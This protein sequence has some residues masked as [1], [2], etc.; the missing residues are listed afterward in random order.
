M[1]SNKLSLAAD[2]TDIKEQLAALTTAVTILTRFAE[3]G[4][5]A[6]FTIA[7]FRVRNRLSE[8][9]F[10][11]LQREGRGPRVM[12]IGSVGRRISREAEADWVRDR[13]AEASASGRRSSAALHHHHGANNGS[14]ETRAGPNDAAG[15]AGPELMR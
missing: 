5:I 7:E 10:H 15:V 2:I 9:Q 8:S 4:E 14:L 6:S 3:Q 12:S 13:E 11:K 1:R